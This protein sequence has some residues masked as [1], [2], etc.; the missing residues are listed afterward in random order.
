MDNLSHALTGLAA[1]ELLHRCLPAE[2]DPARHGLRRR[3][4][5][6]TC[7]LAGNFP[8]LDLVLT[9]LLP[10]PLGYLLHHRGHT[11]TLIYALPQALLLAALLLAMW[12]GARALVRES[13]IARFGFAGALGIGFGLHLA[14]DYLN[15]YGLHPFHPVDSRWFFGD[16][17]FILEPVFWV[18][19]GVPLIAALDR[20]WLRLGLLLLLGA[21]L[22]YFAANGYLHAASLSGLYLLGALLLVLARRPRRRVGVLGA[23]VAALAAFILVQGLASQQAAR[24]IAAVL[25]KAQPQATLLDSARSPFPANPLC[26]NFVA[27]ASDERAG[28]F[29]LQYGVLALAPDLIPLDACPSAMADLPGAVLPQAHLALRGQHQGSLDELRNLHRTNCHFQAWMRFA[30]MPQ[31]AAGVA[32]DLR[33]A[34]SPQGNFTALKLADFASQPCPENVPQWDFPRRDLLSTREK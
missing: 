11:H 9:P 32:S 3:L 31:L 7:A 6:L 10:A 25:Q 5:L 14:M 4:L 13:R 33:F 1:G 27:I 34:D 8:D 26:W 18:A 24:M 17:V 2:S 29:S 16:M 12:P 23:G 21:V 22:A 15:S 30:R 20:R 28:H 19:L